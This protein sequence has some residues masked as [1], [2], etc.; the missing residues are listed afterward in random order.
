MLLTKKLIENYGK[1]RQENEELRIKTLNET[2]VSFRD[3]KI[4][5]S[6]NYF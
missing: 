5:D 6:S 3:I 2:F 1:S 4:N